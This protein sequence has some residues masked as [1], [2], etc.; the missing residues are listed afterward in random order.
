MTETGVEES[1]PR[2]E[3]ELDVTE[4]DNNSLS[5]EELETQAD[6]LLTA[7]SGILKDN[8][9]VQRALA[10][11]FLN[12]GDTSSLNNKERG[13]ISINR[14]DVQYGITTVARDGFDSN[15]EM[16]SVFRSLKGD[17]PEEVT[18]ER[19]GSKTPKL[20]YRKWRTDGSFI[21]MDDNSYA[22]RKAN[23]MLEHVTRDF[24]K[25]A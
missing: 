24:G 7:F 6:R 1:Q 8:A 3:A 9:D 5:K 25:Q 19:E 17:H 13:H 20:Q 2:P 12:F 11:T 23:Q 18:I 10:A 15:R 21:S 4:G 14:D 16:L 22:L